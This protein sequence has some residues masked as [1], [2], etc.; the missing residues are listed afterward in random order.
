MI[1]GGIVLIL[2]GY[3]VPGLG[4]LTTIGVIV[5]VIGLVLLLL[6]SIGRPIGR[7]HYY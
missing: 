6:G 2:L 5:L 4:I 7:R 3:L 1:V